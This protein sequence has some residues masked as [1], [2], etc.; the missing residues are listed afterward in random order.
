MVSKVSFFIRKYWLEWNTQKSYCLWAKKLM[1]SFLDLAKCAFWS[2]LCSLFLSLVF[3]FWSISCLFLWWSSFFLLLLKISLSGDGA[4]M[5]NRIDWIHWYPQWKLTSLDL[6]R[7]YKV[8][9]TW[10]KLPFWDSLS[11]VRSFAFC[12]GPA[13]PSVH[14]SV[15]FP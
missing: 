12:S 5:Y 10:E 3:L 7:K 2:S 1:I 15:V 6:F 4:N 8:Q 11:T 13:C 14:I 9:F